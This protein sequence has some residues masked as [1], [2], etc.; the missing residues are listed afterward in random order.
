MLNITS[1]GNKIKALIQG[2]NGNKAGEI[3]LP[4]N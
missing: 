2:S 4:G 3:F 1:K